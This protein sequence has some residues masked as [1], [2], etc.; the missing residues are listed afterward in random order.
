MTPPF[1]AADPRVRVPTAVLPWRAVDGV[2]VNELKATED[3]AN[4]AETETGAL[5]AILQTLPWTDVQPFQLF[6]VKP[7]A[8][9]AVRAS[10][11][12]FG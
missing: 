7:T 9:T 3:G 8:G 2:N 6:S 10:I 4:A 5:I 1:G 11:L 12:P